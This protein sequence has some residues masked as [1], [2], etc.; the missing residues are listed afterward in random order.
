[1]EAAAHTVDPTAN[2]AE[3]DANTAEV[4]ANTA[5]VVANIVDPAAN[6]AADPAAKTAE[7][8]ATHLQPNRRS[9][10]LLG[11]PT[12]HFELRMHSP[13]RNDS[14]RPHH[15]GLIYLHGIHNSTGTLYC[16]SRCDHSYH[17]CN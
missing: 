3:A 6:T 5:E 15:T 13:E 16:T 7:V 17:L 10:N 1:M 9:F 2:T 12:N 11:F 8:A 14:P 4:V